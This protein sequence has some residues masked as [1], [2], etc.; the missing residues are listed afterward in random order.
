MSLYTTSFG[1]AELT[2]LRGLE[3]LALSE[4]GHALTTA[5]SSDAGGGF[6]AGTS[7][8]G[9]AIPCRLDPLSGGETLVAGRIDERS[10][11]VLSV[12]FGTELDTAQQFV[13][14]SW[15]TFELTAQRKRTQ[16]DVRVY[17]VVEAD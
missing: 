12:P 11:H 17:E 5:G 7:T 10:T 15:G 14:S 1:T 16:E 8:L 3:W 9:T 13:V 6:T 2:Q 4:T